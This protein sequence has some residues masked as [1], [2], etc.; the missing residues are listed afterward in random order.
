MR[1]VT[2][3]R[4]TLYPLA[5]RMKRKVSHAASTRAVSEPIVAEVELSNGQVGYGE[6]LP[7]E[8]VTGETNESVMRLLGPEGEFVK[9][10][11]AVR[12]VGYIEALEAIDSLP[13]LTEEGGGC[14]AARACVELALLD[15]YLP[16][17]QRTPADAVRW[18]GLAGFGY[19]GSIER[20]RYSMVLAS[21]SVSSLRRNCLLAY[22]AGMRHFKL[23]VGF[24][25]D[26]SRLASVMKIIGR[27]IRRGKGSLRVDANSAWT[28]QEAVDRLKSWRSLPIACV[29]QPLPKGREEEL[30]PLRERTGMKVYHDESLVTMDDA[31]YLYEL[32]VADGF[33]IR[34][35]KCGGFLPAMRLAGFARAR[36][37]GIQ[38]G[39][40][41]GETSILSS[42]GV[43]F[44]RSVPRVEYCEGC[45]GGLL[46]C[47]DVVERSV[48]F[49]WGGR[50]PRVG[51]SGIGVAV[52]RE[53]LERHCVESPVVVAL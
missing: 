26:D 10:F 1:P 22:C 14:A 4:L 44:L 38:L 39:C 27:S 46:M 29:E 32:G 19:P 30:I 35:S 40:M 45:F 13:M 17:A 49:G 42:V 36:G 43:H 33:N 15:A 25:D 48:R 47:E 21:E 5:L 2:V 24:A 11:L 50:V 16:C 9:E 37:I 31:R 23:K 6:T 18:L 8:Y 52:K 12:P 34:V 7:R 20:I 41:V 51:D 3:K 28:L 53:L